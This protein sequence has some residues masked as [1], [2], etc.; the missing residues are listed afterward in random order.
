MAT[1]SSS[2]E[3]LRNLGLRRFWFLAN[4]VDRIQAENDLRQAQLLGAV[5]SQ[6]GYTQLFAAL[7]KRM[8][9]IIVSKPVSQTYDPADDEMDPA[10]ERAKFAALKAKIRDQKSM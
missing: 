6:E 5:T 3:E 4:Q 7:S 10:F 1:Y 9:E 2:F 8:G